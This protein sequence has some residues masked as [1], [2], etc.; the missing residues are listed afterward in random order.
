MSPNVIHRPGMRFSIKACSIWASQLIAACI[1]FAGVLSLQADSLPAPVIV[2]SDW[3]LQ[4]VAKVTSPGEEVS[5]AKFQPAGW[6]KATVPGTVLTTLVNDGVYPEP[7]YGENNRPNKIPESLCRTSYWYRTTFTV[8]ESYAGHRV[9][10]NF[11][12]INYHATSG[13]TARR[14][15]R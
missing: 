13:L 11:A 2:S 14:R 10:V 6:Y 1:L 7:L 4:D 12:G 3:Q 9:W 5:A 15:A 8:P